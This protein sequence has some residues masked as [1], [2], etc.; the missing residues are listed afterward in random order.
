MKTLRSTHSIAVYWYLHSEAH[1]V[2][3]K[4]CVCK[5]SHT[6]VTHLLVYT[7]K[8][9]SFCDAPA[10]SLSNYGC[11]NTGYK[12]VNSEI[13]WCDSMWPT[14]R[15]KLTVWFLTGLPAERAE[16]LPPQHPAVSQAGA[17]CQSRQVDI[18]GGLLFQQKSVVKSLLKAEEVILEWMS[19]VIMNDCKLKPSVERGW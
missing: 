14:R 9:I 19:L 13:A 17:L 5:H 18:G 8:P 1:T 12:G 16:R 2:F 7:G 11:R 3:A 15:A 10:D 4:Y 6:H